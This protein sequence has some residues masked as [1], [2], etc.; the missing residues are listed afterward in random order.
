MASTYGLIL[1]QVVTVIRGL[2][3]SGV[4]DANVVRRNVATLRPGDMPGDPCVLVSPNGRV[5]APVSE[6]TN[7]RDDI[8]Y[9]VLVLF[10]KASD[11]S[12]DAD[13]QYLTWLERVR[14]AFNNKALSAVPCVFTC[15]ID[16]RDTYNVDAWLKNLTM[17]AI[18]FRFKSRELRT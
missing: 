9:P 12:Q 4:V 15:L 7:L 16:P 17:G 13:D 8:Y 1:D 10:C 11:Q 18:V 6:G 14:K 5:S 3:L 2:D